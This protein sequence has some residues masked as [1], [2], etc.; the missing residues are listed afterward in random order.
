LDE[1]GFDLF[2]DSAPGLGAAQLTQ[3]SLV[4]TQERLG[5]L[6]EALPIGLLI[7]TAQGILYANPKAAELFDT[8]G[9]TLVGQHLLDHIAREDANGVQT[10]LDRA[11]D[12]ETTHAVEAAIER[13]DDSR[14][15]ANV[16]VG[17]LPWAGNPVV[18]IILQDVTDQKRA[19]ASLRQLSI[20]DELT[21]AYNRR[22]V[23]YEAGLY[24]DA[25]SASGL[26]MS[27]ALLDIDHFKAVN[28]TYGHAAG[29]A[30]LIGL[31]RLVQ[32]LLPSFRDTDSAMFGRIGGEEF[33]VL[34]PG[35]GAKRACDIADRLRKA[36]GSLRIETAAGE[37]AFTSSFGVAT[38]E[39]ADG[40][41]DVMLSRADGALYAAKLQGRN[42]VVL[43]PGK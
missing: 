6:L 27:V 14:R 21:G 35:V 7:H 28:D 40:T 29:D 43:A 22:H 5:A 9:A 12:S 15:V 17:R 10:A 36:I 32:G 13:P 31:T 11:L 42:R 26:P 20:T 16:V 25:A 30:A 8:S 33:V 1:F 38:Y 18:Q 3:Q 34:L 4:D 19:E 37:L 23:F 39:A 2:E 41:F 24:I